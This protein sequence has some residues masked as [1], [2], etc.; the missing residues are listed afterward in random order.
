MSPTSEPSEKPTMLPP[1][2]P[3][4]MPTRAPS[5]EPTISQLDVELVET[6][7]IAQIDKESVTETNEFQ[8]N[9]SNFVNTLL[10]GIGSG[11]FVC[12]LI[13]C[14]TLG[15]KIRKINKEYQNSQDNQINIQYPKQKSAS[16]VKFV[17]DDR[18]QHGLTP[19]EDAPNVIAGINNKMEIRKWLN[20]THSLPQYYENFIE[21]TYESM[22]FVREIESKNDL[23]A[24]GIFGEDKQ[25]IFEA[26]CELQQEAK[27]LASEGKSQQVI[28]GL[29]H[30]AFDSTEFVVLDDE[31]IQT[32]DGYTTAQ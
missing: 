8:E 29:G 1:G 13:I 3:S 16:M 2:Y 18:P 15:C 24:I 5:I 22:A 26:I 27:A 6:T 12:V 23:A 7:V 17:D 28:V 14:I 11:L 20:E 31:E 25:K 4:T 19:V 30:D 32:N 21:N 9:D 10:I